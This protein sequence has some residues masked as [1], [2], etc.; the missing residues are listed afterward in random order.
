MDLEFNVTLKKA[1]T[2]VQKKKRWKAFSARGCKGRYAVSCQQA[3]LLQWRLDTVIF[4]VFYKL[5]QA[6]NNKILP[7]ILLSN[8]LEK[9]KKERKKLDMYLVWLSFT[10]ILKTLQ[11]AGIAEVFRPKQRAGNSINPRAADLWVLNEVFFPEVCSKRVLW[12]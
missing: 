7:W 9:K 1:T 8:H 12:G 2:T 11:S 6:N 5:F 10:L 3:Y 4:K